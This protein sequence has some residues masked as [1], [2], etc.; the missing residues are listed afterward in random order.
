MQQR[1][2]AI[3]GECTGGT[4]QENSLQGWRMGGKIGWL[5]S[6]MAATVMCGGELVAPLEGMGP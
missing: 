2:Y 4:T 6:S 5:R 1:S 3:S